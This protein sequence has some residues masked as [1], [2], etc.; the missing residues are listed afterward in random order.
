MEY[1]GSDVHVGTSEVRVLS[2]AGKV[3]ERSTVRT[4]RAALRKHF[5]GR[6]RVRIE[7]EAGGAR[8]G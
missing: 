8:H 6:E 3:E 7:I 4:T 1:C 5:E 2:E